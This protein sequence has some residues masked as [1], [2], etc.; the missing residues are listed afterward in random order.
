MTLRRDRAQLEARR[1][2]GYELL[3]QGVRP[4][5]IARR[6]GVSRAAV[7]RWKKR[8]GRRGAS[9]LRSLGPPGPKPH[10][11]AAQGQRLRRLLE[12]GAVAQGW[13]NELWTLGRVA[14]LIQRQFSWRC[15]P[16]H[17]SR[18]LHALGLSCQKPEGR[19]REQNP[20]ALR[21]WK[22]DVWPRLKKKPG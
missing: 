20:H 8:A 17:V 7:S 18:L 4:S 21:T 16:A 5:E 12:Q 22:R 13:E 6:H 2:A 19:A 1:L 3:Q 9:A 11:T 10:L 15:H 14:Q